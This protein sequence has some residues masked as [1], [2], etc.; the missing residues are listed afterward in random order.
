MGKENSKGEQSD[1]RACTCVVRRASPSTTCFGLSADKV[2]VHL[3]ENRQKGNTREEVVIAKEKEKKEN[4]KAWMSIL[5]ASL[6]V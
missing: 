6:G 1:L 5:L 2:I 4:V 3:G